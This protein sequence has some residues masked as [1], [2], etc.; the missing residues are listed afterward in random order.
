MEHSFFFKST[1]L[2]VIAGEDEETN[3][4]RF[5]KSVAQWLSK[6][7][8]ENGFDASISAEDW[9]WRIDC[10]SK[11]FPIW[12]GCG[13]FEETDGEGNWKEPSIDDLTW[14]C[15]IESDKPFFKKIL[16][17]ANVDEEVNEL[18]NVLY[19]ILESTEHISF[20]S[21]P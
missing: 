11:P 4:F 6:K 7:L 14:Q 9:G 1:S 20:V 19:K 15:F 10:L 13:N 3:P 8:A 5:G 16:N 2:K 17:M 12:V 18:S 21:E